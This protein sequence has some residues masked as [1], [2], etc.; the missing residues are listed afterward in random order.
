MWSQPWEHRLSSYPPIHNAPFDVVVGVGDE[1][2]LREKAVEAVRSG[3]L[4]SRR[5]DRL[6]GVPGSGGPC[7]VC[8]E[9]LTADEMEIQLQC[10]WNDGTSGLDLFHPHHRC[11]AAWEFER[12]KTE[13]R[14][15]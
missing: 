9:P 4:P 6:F 1:R 8:G 10:T 3:Q 5:S 13:E 7:A 14:G 12:A 2:T 15:Q 11:Y